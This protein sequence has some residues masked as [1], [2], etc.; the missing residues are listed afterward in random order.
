MEKEASSHSFRPSIFEISIL[1][2]VP[3]I[4]FTSL[5]ILKLIFLIA[6]FL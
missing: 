1:V 6:L 3:L 4:Y 2:E 5:L